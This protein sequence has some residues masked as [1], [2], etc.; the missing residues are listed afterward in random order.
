MTQYDHT[1]CD[2]TVC[3][4][5]SAVSGWQVGSAFNFLYYEGEQIKEDKMVRAIHVGFLQGNQME[6]D[7]L[8]D[9][10]TY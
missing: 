5:S 6:T 4:P 7:H 10:S 8:Q 3:D 1:C 2:K 9:S